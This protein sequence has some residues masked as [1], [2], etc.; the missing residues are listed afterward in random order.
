M[1]STCPHAALH[2][3]FAGGQT[4]HATALEEHGYRYPE[5]FGAF[6]QAGQ[7]GLSFQEAKRMAGVSGLG[8]VRRAVFTAAW[9][10]GRRP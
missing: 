10:A 2:E 6:Y 3:P 9:E 5:E 4:A 8:E 7:E 1:L